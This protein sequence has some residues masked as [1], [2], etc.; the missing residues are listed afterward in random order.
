MIEYIFTIITNIN[1]IIT[2]YYFYSFCIYFIFS[3][4]FFTFS[5]PGGLIV[6][7][8]SGFFFGLFQGFIINIFSISIGSLLF[9][10]LSKNLL[11]KIFNNYYIKF[12]SKIS[13]YIKNSSFEYLILLRL[14][15]GPPLVLQNL[16]ISLLNINKTKIFVTS[17]IGFTPL[18]FLFAYLGSFTSTLIQLKSYTF[19]QVFSFDILIIF[20]FLILL[21]LL[22]I[23]FKKQF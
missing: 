8:C 15:I 12:S 16:F 13:G 4:C 23:Y 6:S 17:I 1:A 5:L 9:I 18:M 20:G 10:Y 21:T 19:S 2:D 22:R 3:I 7:L 14:I 11:S